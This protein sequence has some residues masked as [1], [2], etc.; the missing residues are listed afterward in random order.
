LREATAAGAQARV[1]YRSAQKF[2]VKVNNAGRAAAR[3]ATA[4]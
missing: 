2:A 3:Q 4:A 1:L